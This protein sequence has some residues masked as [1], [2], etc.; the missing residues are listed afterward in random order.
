[1]SKSFDIDPTE[2]KSDFAYDVCPSDKTLVI[3]KDGQTIELS[4]W[5]AILLQ[6]ILI[7]H[8]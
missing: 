1:M 7:K 6:N 3:V 4:Y 2:I 8:Y 5:E